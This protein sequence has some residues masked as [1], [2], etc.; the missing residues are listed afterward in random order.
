MPETVH[1]DY[2]VASLCVCVCMGVYVCVC[3]CV[4]VCMC[5]H[6]HVPCV[7]ASMDGCKVIYSLQ[8]SILKRKQSDTVH[9]FSSILIT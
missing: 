8:L 3:V 9:F 6:M 4:C 1:M 5:V 7:C 2:K